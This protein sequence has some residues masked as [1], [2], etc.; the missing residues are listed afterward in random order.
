MKYKCNDCEHVFEGSSYSTECP[1]C[2]SNSFIPFK[3]GSGG[4]WLDKIKEW[5]KENK[6]IAAV[7]VIII[8]LLTT[9]L[10]TLF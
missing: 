3:N 6:L 4:G 10:Y 9:H 2:E 8:L 5:V 1:E 7:I